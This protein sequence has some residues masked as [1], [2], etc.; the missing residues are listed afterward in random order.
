MSALDEFVKA[1]AT[2]FL[3]SVVFVDDRIY[4]LQGKPLQEVVQIPDIRLRSQFVDPARNPASETSPSQVMPIDPK[5]DG[6]PTP[7]LAASTERTTE[8]V[9]AE[10]PE[11]HPRELMESFAREGVICALYEPKP[12][13]STSS[14]SEIFKLCERADVVILDWDLHKDDGAAVSALLSNLIAVS[15]A[16]MPH[17]VRLC[18]IY[19][20]RPSLRPVLDSL[21]SKLKSNGCKVDVVEGK[22]I[23]AAGATRI[24]ILGKPSTTGRPSS[25]KEYEVKESALASR[26][27]TEFSLVHHGIL[28]AFALNGLAAVRRNSKRLLDKFRGELDGAFL[29]HRSLVQEDGEAFH[30]LPEML[31]DEIRAILEDSWPKAISHDEIAAAASGT[32][33]LS[34]CRDWKDKSSGKPRSAIPVF[35]EFLKGPSG[36]ELARSASHE[37]PKKDDDW[38]PAVL[39]DCA[40]MLTRDGV[41][42]TEHLASLFCNRTHYSSE[43]RVLQFGT[44]VRHRAGESDP[45]TYSL[46]LMPICDGQ[47]L[48]TRTRFPFWRL[49]ENAKQAISAKRFGIVVIDNENTAH[50]LAAGGKIRDM[51]WLAEF[52][53]SEGTVRANKAGSV[54]RFS[55]T[56][57]VE[58]VAEL[59]PLHAQRVAAFLGGEVSRVGLVESEWLRLLC[60]R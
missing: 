39:T 22:M 51:L 14:E 17:H 42:S 58:W 37:I 23:L 19:T 28:P 43:T 2:R 6:N 31:S 52:E 56:P 13:F 57:S 48:Q 5:N 24:L 16:V 32:V 40:T 1:S 34:A 27:L 21:L 44:V 10:E 55:S 30:E 4:S 59:K 60:D 35:R 33:Q 50:C 36:L 38:K 11:Y 12:K 53:P 7:L 18:A 29:F 26:I 41:S 9:S 25:D 15:E 47:R 49:K 3:Q 54:F 45:W 8:T 46:C 20:T